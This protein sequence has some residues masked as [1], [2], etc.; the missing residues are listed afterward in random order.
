MPVVSI[1]LAPD[2]PF[3]APGATL[4]YTVSATNTTSISQCFNYWEKA[5]LPNST[6]YPPS[7]A[8]FGPVHLCLNPWASIT[9]HLTHGVPLVAPL[10]AYTLNA[11]TGVYPYIVVSDGRFD[12]TVTS[13]V[14]PI[15]SPQ[16]SWRLIENGFM[17]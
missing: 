16:T 8:L 6:T 9:T 12:F 3:V 5:T 1:L 2:A 7:G 17:K 10:G 13:P 15:K 4:G 11:F 14:A